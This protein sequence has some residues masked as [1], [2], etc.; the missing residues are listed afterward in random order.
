MAGDYHAATDTTPAVHALPETL[1]RPSCRSSKATPPRGPPS[2]R[3]KARR[4]SRSGPSRP[5]RNARS[6][7][8]K[9]RWQRPR[10]VARPHV[11]VKSDRAANA[12]TPVVNTASTIDAL[13]SP[14]FAN[15]WNAGL[16]ASPTPRRPPRRLRAHRNPF[17]DSAW[18]DAF[19]QKIVW[20]VDRQQQRAELHVIRPTWAVEV[21]MNLGDEKRGNRF[22]SPPGGAR[23]D[24]S[25]LSDLRNA[26]GER[27]LSLG[28]ALVSADSGPPASRWPRGP[29]SPRR[30]G[31]TGR[32]CGSRPKS[33]RGGFLPR[34]GRRPVRV[35]G[36]GLPPAYG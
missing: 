16:G 22:S 15:R 13:A 21:M 23:G 6:S 17:G 11:P 24:R 14:A 26:L 8:S 32:R 2:P 36:R 25:L 5:S 33:F 12:D 10:P 31:G 19:Q 3:S 4:S 20:L 1:A 35:A 28:E 7:R 27:G 29:E 9:S 34:P 18:G 30:R